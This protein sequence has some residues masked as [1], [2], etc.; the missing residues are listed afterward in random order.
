[1]AP[2]QHSDPNRHSVN[3]H[4]E[5]EQGGSMKYDWAFAV[6][7]PGVLAFTIP[8]IYYVVVGMLT[9]VALLVEVRGRGRPPEKRGWT[10]LRIVILCGMALVVV[11]N[12]LEMTSA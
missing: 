5:G 1:M 9:I 11:S 8:H 3:R 4:G 7:Y 10:P 2:R 12:V 6:G